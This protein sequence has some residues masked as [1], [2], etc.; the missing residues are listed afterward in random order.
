M[1][2]TRTALNYAANKL[3]PK[4]LE[5]E[6]RI[7]SSMLIDADYRKQVFDSLNADDFYVSA[8]KVIFEKCEEMQINGHPIEIQTIWANLNDHQRKVI[9]TQH[10]LS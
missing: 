2:T 1:D 9:G 8:H 6:E 3:P 10:K 4:E 5:I 7:I